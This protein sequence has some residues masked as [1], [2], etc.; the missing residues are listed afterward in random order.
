[1]GVAWARLGFE[2]VPAPFGDPEADLALLRDLVGNQPLRREDDMVRRLRA[3]TRFIDQLVVEWV[4]AGHPQVVTLGAGYDARSLRYARPGCRFFEVDL[5]LTQQD[6]RSRLGRL[7]I[8]ESAVTFLV[9][10]LAV[11]D[12]GAALVMSG[13]NSELETLVLAE[14]LLAYLDEATITRTLG[15]CRAVVG[16]GSRLGVSAASATRDEVDRRDFN[17]R[18]A[19]LGEPVRSHLSVP[20]LTTLLQPLGWGRT[21]ESD[22][23]TDEARG[24]GVFEVLPAS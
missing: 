19:E 12:V 3:R 2:R 24:F 11:D 14:G 4:G 16:D 22:R 9:A 8:D 13:L 1:L 6:K 17:R 15:R 5:P 7:G 18:V 21:A 20:E 10:D 23:L